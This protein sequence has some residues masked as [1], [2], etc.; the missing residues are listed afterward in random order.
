MSGI[1]EGEV[2]VTSIDLIIDYL[3]LKSKIGSESENGYKLYVAEM[4]V[5][6]IV[7]IIWSGLLYL[8]GY[9]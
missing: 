2:S 4:W 6:V 5:G 7:V 1:F 8:I 3:S 9:Y